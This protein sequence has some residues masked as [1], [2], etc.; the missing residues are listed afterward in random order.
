MKMIKMVSPRNF[1]LRTAKGHSVV[2][3]KNEPVDVPLVIFDDAQ[4]VGAVP[5]DEADV[6]TEEE[7][8]AENI[9][10]GDEREAAIIASFDQVIARNERGDYTAGGVPKAKVIEALVGFE[11]DLREVRNLWTPFM[12]NRN[13]AD[14]D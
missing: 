10:V 13:A 3:K 12:A 9:P 2:F 4:S 6:P 1:T 7:T 14:A 11:V 8:A 5:V